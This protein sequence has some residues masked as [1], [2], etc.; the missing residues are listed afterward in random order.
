MKGTFRGIEV[1]GFE[2][3]TT[4]K[5]KFRQGNDGAQISL[6]KEAVS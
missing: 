4:L 3:K 5:I 6:N 1:E 2:N